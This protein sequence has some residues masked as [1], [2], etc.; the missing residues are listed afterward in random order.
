MVSPTLY[1]DEVLGDF[2]FGKHRSSSL[3]ADFLKNSTDT[4]LDPF[5]MNRACGKCLLSPRTWWICLLPSSAN[6]HPE[7]SPVWIEI[8]APLSEANAR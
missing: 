7:W 1:S 3:A 5:P 2:P 4:D 8:L 6:N